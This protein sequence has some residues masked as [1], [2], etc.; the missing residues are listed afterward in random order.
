[1]NVPLNIRVITFD[2]GGTLIEP[3]PS[4]GH[5]Y[6]RVAGEHGHDGIDPDVLNRQFRKAWLAKKGFDHSREAWSRLVAETFQG[7]LLGPVE[8]SLF[9]A[10]YLRFASPTVWRVF[11]DARPMLDRLQHQGFRLGVISNWDARL[12]P[13]LADLNLTQYFEC[14]VISCE[15]ERPSP[16]PGYLREPGRNL[17]R[18]QITV[19]MWEMISRMTFVEAGQPASRPCI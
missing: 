18:A 13:L 9:Q 17:L 12:R 11:D 8:D 7:L 6:A 10:L 1:M 4:V 16:R 19:C 5:V 2:V 14:L 15:V 3:W